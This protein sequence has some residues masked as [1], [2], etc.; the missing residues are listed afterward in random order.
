MKTPKQIRRYLRKQPWYKAWLKFTWMSQPLKDFI[1]FARGKAGV[2]TL[3]GFSWHN[4]VQGNSFW[5]RASANFS[6]WYHHG[7]E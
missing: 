4:T 7:E 3:Q 6:E 2:D 1:R 5:A